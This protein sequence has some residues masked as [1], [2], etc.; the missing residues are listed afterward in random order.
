LLGDSGALLARGGRQSAFQRLGPPGP[1]GRG[2]L[3]RRFDQE[4]L[5]V[6]GDRSPALGGFDEREGVFAE[7]LQQRRVGPARPSDSNHPRRKGHVVIQARRFGHALEIGGEHRAEGA[8]RP[9]VPDGSAAR[10]NQHRQACGPSSNQAV[11][12]FPRSHRRSLS[13]DTRIRSGRAPF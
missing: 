10:D 5:G 8:L 3:R 4:I 6:S 9:L 11:R 2:Q 12:G 13:V 7:G 1:Q